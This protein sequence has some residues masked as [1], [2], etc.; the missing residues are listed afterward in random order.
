[1]LYI[2]SHRW[3]IAKGAAILSS[4]ALLSPL[5]SAETTCLGER[6]PAQREIAQQIDSFE[7]TAALTRSDLDRYAAAARSG[8][9]HKL[10]HANGLNHAK[11][12]VN[13]LG[14]QMNELESLNT[15]GTVLQQAV[16]R[17]AR[18]HLELLVD[19][20]QDAIVMMN[21]DTKAYRSQDF[22]VAVNEMYEQA[23]Q[24]YTRVNT[25]TDFEKACNRAVDVVTASK[26]GT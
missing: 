1:M 16:I 22:R 8:D 10:S 11:E 25:L 9:L 19:H 14:K 6:T 24:L 15:Q 20:V 4:F 7:R 17:E 12:N 13:L 21:G 2:K 23:D 26:T 5:A 3:I 18:P